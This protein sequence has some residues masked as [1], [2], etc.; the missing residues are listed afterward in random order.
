VKVASFAAAILLGLSTL[1]L[2]QHEPAGHAA[3]ATSQTTSAEQAQAP[4]PHPEISDNAAWTRPMLL[5]ILA[6]FA[7]AIPV[8]FIVRAR[9][10]R[11]APAA[12]GHDDSHSSADSHRHENHDGHR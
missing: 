12:H 9:T 3:P 5:I 6:L 1:C 7:V 8:G 2:A 11:E 10:P 4:L